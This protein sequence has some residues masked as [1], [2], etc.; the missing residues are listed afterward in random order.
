MDGRL[1][2]N[3]AAGTELSEGLG[4]QAGASPTPGRNFSPPPEETGEWRVERLSAK[5]AGTYRMFS[6]T[7]DRDSMIND[8]KAAAAANRVEF[9]AD[10]FTTMM[11]LE[12]GKELDKMTGGP[13]HDEGVRNFEFA[14]PPVGRGGASPTPG[15]NFSLSLPPP[16]ETGEWRVERLSAKAAGVYRMFSSKEDRDSVINDMKAA[17]AAN[18]VEFDA[19]PFTTMMELEVGKELDKMTGG[20]V[21]DEGVRN[22]KF[23]DPPVGRGGASPTPGHNF[24]SSLPP[25]EETGEWR[26]ERLSAKAAGAYRMF[27][28]KEDRDSVI[29]DMKAAAAANRFEFDADPFT[30]TMELEVGKELD[31]M[32]GG[33]IHDEDVRNFEFA[34]PPEGRGGGATTTVDLARMKADETIAEATSAAMKVAKEAGDVVAGHKLF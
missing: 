15:H 1:P 16:E 10:P 33:P 29:N 5:A 34:D 12:V 11:E 20:P 23:A 18:R 27:S 7:E 19:V 26:V 31:K 22:F 13:V 25:P 21:H 32:T 14:D 4:E 30:T 8:M 2:T 24:S 9:D 3:A 6:S 17:A 28:S